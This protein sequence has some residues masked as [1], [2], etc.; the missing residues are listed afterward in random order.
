MTL[1][2]AI[3]AR[4]DR[5][6]KLDGEWR[7]VSK[8]RPVAIPEVGAYVRAEVDDKGFLKSIEPLNAGA[9]LCTSDRDERIARLA[10]LKAAANFA[11][12]RGDI[13]SSD[14]LRIADSWLSWV[15]REDA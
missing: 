4:N 2:G 1:E 10:V 15:V 13:K 9:P 7:N 5:G 8:F 12:A 11:A 14:V 3:E 6:I